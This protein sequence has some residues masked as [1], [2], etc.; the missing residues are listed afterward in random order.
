M[1]CALMKFVHFENKRVG[2]SV[3]HWCGEDCD[4]SV[5][6]L[7]NVTIVYILIRSIL[8]VGIF[9]RSSVEIIRPEDAIGRIL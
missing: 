2:N 8:I 9:L 7:S 1:N 5:S 4:D 3:K 6:M